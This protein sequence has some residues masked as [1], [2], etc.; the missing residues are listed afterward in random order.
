MV[1]LK[2]SSSEQLFYKKRNNFAC[3]LE[4]GWG[5]DNRFLAPGVAYTAVSPKNRPYVKH[6]YALNVKSI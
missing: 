6:E 1:D 3:R 5:S 2:K 4:G